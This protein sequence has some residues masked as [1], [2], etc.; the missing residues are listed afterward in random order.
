MALPDIKVNWEKEDG[1]KLALKL[2]AS[3]DCEGR[4]FLL[5]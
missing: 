5:Q 4:I 3:W 2:I 1:G